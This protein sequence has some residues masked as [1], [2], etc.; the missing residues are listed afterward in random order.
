LAKGQGI[1]TLGH[2]GRTWAWLLGELGA[3][4]FGYALYQAPH[5]GN[6]LIHGPYRPIPIIDLLHCHTKTTT[7]ITTNFTIPFRVNLLKVSKSVDLG[8]INNN[9]NK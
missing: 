4:A 3:Q 8:G 9:N 6:A 2:K 1:R 7:K 5:F